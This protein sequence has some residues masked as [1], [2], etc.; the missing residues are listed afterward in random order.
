MTPVQENEKAI[1]VLPLAD[2]LRLCR[3]LPRFIGR[4]PVELDWQRPVIGE[5]VRDDSSHRVKRPVQRVRS[6]LPMF[7]ASVIIPALNSANSVRA[8]VASVLANDYGDFEVIVVDDGSVDE[9]ARIAESFQDSRV[10]VLISGRSIGAGACRNLGA[11]AARGALLFFL[12]A[13]CVAD[14]NWL[15]VGCELFADDTVHGVEGAVH[16]AEKNPV[17]QDKIPIN[18]LYNLRC[19]DPINGKGG[20]FAAGNMAYRA[21]TFAA[22]SGFDAPRFRDGRE[23]TDLG[24]RVADKGAVLF[25]PRMRV[26]HRHERWTAKTLLQNAR[27][28]EA[29]VL[30]LK[31]H[32]DFCYRRGV[33]L[34]P[35]LLLGLLFP[36]L[37]V[38]RLW[39]WLG[40]ARDF[41]FLFVVYA[42]L[43]KLRWHIWRAA[44]KHKILAL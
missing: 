11:R 37:L 14:P 33:V 44:L 20:D 30:L 1:E 36:P 40:S 35:D 21:T 38:L 26:V 3:D 18:P 15:R 27:R 42:Y 17:L 22:V 39:P 5:C 25:E 24:L 41:V 16:Y 28:Y 2:Q 7:R 32:G 10:R 19:V 13:D 12:D 31:L 4:A 6:F 9:T 8:C 23:D 29:D 34:H 43:A